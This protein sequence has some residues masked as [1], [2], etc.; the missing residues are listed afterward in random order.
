MKNYLLP[1]LTALALLG[2]CA[3]PTAVETQTPVESPAPVETPAT[4]ETPSNQSE[5]D[6]LPVTEGLIRALYITEGYEVRAVEPYEED[7]LVEYGYPNNENFS[8]LGWVFGNTGRRVQLTA[9]EEF[10]HYQIMGTGVVDYRTSGV[11]AAVPW[12]GMPQ[13]GW[14][15][16]LGDENGVVSP[17]YVQVYDD[18]QTVWEDPRQD[19]YMGVWDNG[20][21]PWEDR[22]FQLYDAR[23]DAD[24]LSFSFIPD[25]SSVE[26]FNSFFPAA[27][28]IP[29]LQ[30]TCDGDGNFTLRLYN[31]CLESS[32]EDLS[33]FGPYE[34]LYPCAIPAGSLG[35]DNH[36]LTDVAI[37]QE[38]ADVVISGRLTEKA[39][40]FRA[41]SFNLGYD[42]IPAL[43]LT[44]REALY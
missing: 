3:A 10:T 35:R 2:A 44:F 40:S 43:R 1:L 29:S 9:M 17:D 36:F 6:R 11:N 21:A 42:T 28:T 20:P 34:G 25:G 14:V 32:G 38:G 41:E 7:F 37:A 26:R 18:R 24:G 16:V 15:Q 4:P 22:W 31:T 12:K 13:G 23:I 39:V 27:T 5:F 33:W 19:F 8:L 30:T